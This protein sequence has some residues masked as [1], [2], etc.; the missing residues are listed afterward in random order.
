MAT[1][2]NTPSALLGSGIGDDENVID[3][4]VT[5]IASSTWPTGAPRSPL[6]HASCNASDEANGP[7]NAVW[8][9]A[10]VAAGSPVTVIASVA[11]APGS[12]PSPCALVVMIGVR[13]ADSL[14]SP[15]GPET[16][17]IPGTETVATHE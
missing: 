12:E 10:S 8:M 2:L 6:A 17:V 11:E 16:G 7:Y 15:Q 3:G 9:V 5:P 1:K 4:P 13:I 14:S